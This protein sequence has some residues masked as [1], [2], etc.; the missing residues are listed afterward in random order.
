MQNAKPNTDV[1]AMAFFNM[2]RKYHDAAGQLFDVSQGRPKVHGQRSLSDPINFLYFH[3][4]ELALKAFLRSHGLPILGTERQSHELTEL[5]Q[6][7]RTLGLLVGS[8][9]RIGIENIVNLLE[10]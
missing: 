1:H 7:C 2:A 10:R 6:E 5:Y 4:A 3:A 8:D 9:D